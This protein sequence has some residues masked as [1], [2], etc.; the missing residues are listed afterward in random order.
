MQPFSYYARIVRYGDLVRSVTRTAPS[1]LAN[2]TLLDQMSS[3]PLA[4]Y[5]IKRAS[6][7]LIKIDVLIDHVNPAYLTGRS[8]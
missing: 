7:K 3:V 6:F 4:S 1:E 8:V 2:V 5:F